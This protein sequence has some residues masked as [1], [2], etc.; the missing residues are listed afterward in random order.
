MAQAHRLRIV[1][2]VSVQ[3]GVRSDAGDGGSRDTLLP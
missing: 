2:D 1:D 3:A